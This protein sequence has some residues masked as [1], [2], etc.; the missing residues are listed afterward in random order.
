MKVSTKSTDNS[1]STGL[2]AQKDLLMNGFINVNFYKS[3]M[4]IGVE[5]AGFSNDFI[6]YY[7]NPKNQ[8]QRKMN[9]LFVDNYVNKC[10]NP[11]DIINQLG[12]NL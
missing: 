1:I 9:Q 4:T 3:H 11:S 7:N 6:M 8:K 10:I 5:V 12:I 2:V